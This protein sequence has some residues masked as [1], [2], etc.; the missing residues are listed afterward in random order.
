MQ[1]RRDILK[2]LFGLAFSGIANSVPNLSSAAFVLTDELRDNAA[3][4]IQQLWQSLSEIESDF[5]RIVDLLSSKAKKIRHEDV[6]VLQWLTRNSLLE[7]IDNVTYSK[8]HLTEL[9]LPPEVLKKLIAHEI[10]WQE[11]AERDDEIK[12]ADCISKLLEESIYASEETLENRLAKF[13]SSCD[14][15]QEL[16]TR[17]C[18][19]NNLMPGKNLS[20]FEKDV[21]IS[22]HLDVYTFPDFASAA[23]ALKIGKLPENVFVLV[24]DRTQSNEAPKNWVERIKENSQLKKI[25]I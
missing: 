12:S 8:K 17:F 1:S 21:E 6:Y 13:R 25:A 20:F 4:N 10:D 5:G 22:N 15:V 2:Q 24:K 18:R 9:N 3:A 23:K 16:A 7:V 19:I 14:S 11:F